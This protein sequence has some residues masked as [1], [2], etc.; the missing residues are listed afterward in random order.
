[1]I[2][3]MKA[4]L[5]QTKFKDAPIVAVAAKCGESSE[6]SIGIDEMVCSLKGLTFIPTR[7]PDGPFVFSVDHCFTIKG[8]G[9]VMTG[10]AL[11]GSV[12]VNS[13]RSFNFLS[14]CCCV[15]YLA[16]LEHR[17]ICSQRGAESQ[18][19]PDV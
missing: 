8:Q 15:N 14:C 9:T 7:N 1:M 5:A 12:Q 10:T 18:I 4:T 3:K 11:S 17:D 13:V 16:C 2:K 19:D 6:E